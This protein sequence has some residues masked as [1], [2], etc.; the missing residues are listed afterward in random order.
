MVTNYDTLKPFF[1]IVI[2]TYNC[3]E[4]LQRALESVFS[5]TYQDF[6]VIVVDNS[7]TDFTQ[8]VLN[9]YSD[10]RINIIEVEKIE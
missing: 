5:Q 8:N 9:S 3:A 10:P 2:P 1:S 6:E 4:F 7:S